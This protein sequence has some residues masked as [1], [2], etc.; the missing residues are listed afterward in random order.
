MELHGSPDQRLLQAREK[1]E[2]SIS[3]PATMIFIKK[4]QAPGIRSETLKAPQ[5]RLDPM[6]RMEQTEQPGCLELLLLQVREKM[7]IFI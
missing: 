3:I 5:A 2:T 1:T 7:E 6:V 4:S